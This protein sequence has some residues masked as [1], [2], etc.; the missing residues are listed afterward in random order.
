MTFLPFLTILSTVLCISPAQR[1]TTAQC[2]ASNA[3]SIPSCAP[4]TPPNSTPLC[5]TLP[6][7]RC[8]GGSVGSFFCCGGPNETA[9][10]G[11]RVGAATCFD[12]T[13]DTCCDDSSGTVCSGDTPVCCAGVCVRDAAACT[14]PAPPTASPTTLP[15][16][17]PT[18][19]INDC[20]LAD[21][22]CSRCLD[23]PGCFYC[24]ATGQCDL[25]GS[26]SSYASCS[27]GPQQCAASLG[28]SCTACQSWQYQTCA[29]PGKVIVGSTVAGIVCALCCICRWAVRPLVR[30]ARRWSRRRR[31]PTGAASDDDDDDGAPLLGL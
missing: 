21:N 4:F 9:A 20:R 2:V 11:R 15:T 6:E 3:S 10:C 22:D 24:P 23:T 26:T 31:G 25:C 7:A 12:P 27:V 8:V 1:P 14:T 17:A 5:C 18:V 28:L 13:H 29:V 30:R 16:P 19:F